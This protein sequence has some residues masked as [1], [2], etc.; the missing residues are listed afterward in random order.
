M[1]VCTTS[2]KNNTGQTVT[3]INLGAMISRLINKGVLLID[4]D[5]AYK[6]I[7]HYLSDSNFCKGLDEFVNFRN[8]GMLDSEETFKNCIKEVTSQIHIMASN[9]CSRLC[10]EDIKTLKYYTNRVYPLT[11]IDAVKNDDFNGFLD[12]S[13]LIIIV[14]N[15]NR[16]DVLEMLKSDC[17]N[18]YK[19]KIIFI[20]NKYMNQFKEEKIYYTRDEIMDDLAK[21]GFSSNEIYTLD[22][23]AN[24]INE[25]NDSTILNFMN[26]NS[27]YL[28]KLEH[29]SKKILEQYL[30]YSFEEEE[31]ERDKAKGGIL[32]WIFLKKLQNSM[33]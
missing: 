17:C 11:I 5:I 20:I 12:Y 30:G 8:T 33:K 3:S 25:S 22:F 24:I 18:L 16:Q 15:Q 32:K 4:T 21:K 7:E 28:V 26:M 23:D 9:Q 27:P 19:D 13:D 6:G 2:F 1:L 29:I 14:L 31:G 10:D